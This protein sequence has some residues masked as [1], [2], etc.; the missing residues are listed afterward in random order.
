MSLSTTAVENEEP[1]V[2]QNDSS[3]A[4]DKSD[5]SQEDAADIYAADI[6]LIPYLP[7][8]HA[9]A[10]HELLISDSGELDCPSFDY[11]DVSPPCKSINA[12]EIVKTEGKSTFSTSLTG[13]WMSEIE[14]PHPV[15]MEA[16]LLKFM[17]SESQFFFEYNDEFGSLEEFEE[18]FR[19]HCPD[20]IG[21]QTTFY[22]SDES[23]AIGQRD[24]LEGNLHF[25]FNSFSMSSSLIALHV[26]AS[27][28]GLCVICK[29][30]CKPDTLPPITTMKKIFFQ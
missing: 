11:V 28:T 22:T 13:P 24:E 20:E 27:P 19:T 30:G 14:P 2:P 18:R 7:N 21:E 29:A 9:T 4:S 25:A 23:H 10:L 5:G 15:G 17:S 26:H 16:A 6:Y 1:A 12:T 8:G 3:S